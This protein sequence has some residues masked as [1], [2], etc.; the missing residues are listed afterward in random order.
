[1]RR[2][3]DERDAL[4]AAGVQHIVGVHLGSLVGAMEAI[5]R[6]Y[7]NFV[8]GDIVMTNNPYLATHQPDCVVCRPMFYQGGQIGFAVNIGH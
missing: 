3:P 6:R 1:M 8:E 5:C 4:L 7:D 2:N